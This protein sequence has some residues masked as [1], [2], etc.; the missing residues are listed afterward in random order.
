MSIYYRE[1]E[2]YKDEDGNDVE[3]NRVVYDRTD[4]TGVD[5]VEQTKVNGYE[6]GHRTEHPDGTVNNHGCYNDEEEENE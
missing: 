1:T 6:V 3:I 4:G 5:Y 2:N